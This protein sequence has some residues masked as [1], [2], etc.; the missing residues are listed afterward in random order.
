MKYVSLISRT[1]VLMAVALLL[2]LAPARGQTPPAVNSSSDYKIAPEDVIT[3][4][5]VG[6]KDLTQDCKVTSSGTITFAWLNNFEVV[7]KTPSQIE[8][9][10]RTALDKDYLVNPTVI[11]AL[12][13][14]RQREVNVLG[15]V[16]KPGAVPIPAERPMTIVDAITRAGGLTARGNKNRIEFT[17][18]RTGKKQQLRLDELKAITDPS[19]NIYVEPGDTIEVGQSVL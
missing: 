12:K 10:I 15:E 19:R 9:A 3:I 16:G 5:V 8:Q 14:Y 11:V 4:G 18:K 1:A 17:S 13:E 6:E 7:G 2:S